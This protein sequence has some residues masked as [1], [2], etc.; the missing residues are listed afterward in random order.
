MEKLVTANEVARHVGENVQTVYRKARE[1]EYPYHK[2]GRLV[3]FKLSEID[4]WTM[5]GGNNAKKDGTRC[6]SNLALK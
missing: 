3:R 6:S 4:E 5:K 2:S 1:G